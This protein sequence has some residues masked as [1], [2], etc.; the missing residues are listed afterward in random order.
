M[1]ISKRHQ[2]S[3]LALI[4]CTWFKHSDVSLR[5]L[6]YTA[7]QMFDDGPLSF[8]YEM[9]NSRVAL[10]EAL[11]RV[12]RMRE[13][14]YV[15]IASHGSSGELECYNGDVVSIA[16]LIGKLSFALDTR[17]VSLT[18]LHLS[19]CSFGS[20]ENLQKILNSVPKLSW[21]SGYSEEVD[22][23]GSASLDMQFIYHLLKYDEP[24]PAQQIKVVTDNLTGHLAGAISDFGFSVL[25]RTGKTV[26]DLFDREKR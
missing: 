9:A 17:G 6:I 19:A 2:H 8:H 21:I 15:Y 25:L 18:G 11:D 1:K 5:P 3:G 12:I 13:I 4:E 26:S 23:L 20:R 22:W 14:K 7:T 16:D 24:T 10:F